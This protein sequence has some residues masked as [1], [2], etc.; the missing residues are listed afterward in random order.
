[1]LISFS[2]QQKEQVQGE[3]SIVSNSRIDLIPVYDARA[4]LSLKTEATATMN[5]MPV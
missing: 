1:M 5:S 3:L 4:F 2:A